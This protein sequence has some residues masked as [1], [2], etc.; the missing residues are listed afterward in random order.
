MQAVAGWSAKTVLSLHPPRGNTLPGPRTACFSQRRPGQEGEDDGHD[1]DV[2]NVVGCEGEPENYH[3]LADPALQG[4]EGQKEG[5]CVASFVA[6]A[7]TE[8]MPVGRAVLWTA[9][10]TVIQPSTTTPLPGLP[11]NQEHHKAKDDGSGS[12]G[13]QGCR[14][15][16]GQ[17]D[18][19][20]GEHSRWGEQRRWGEHS[21]RRRTGDGTWG[22]LHSRQLTSRMHDTTCTHGLT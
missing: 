6:Q 9:G 5:G 7:C 1:G 4:W 17:Q 13:Q 22:A 15:G 19:R 20:W 8:G 3:T 12:L 16:G 2:P 11:H 10:N 18:R 21:R 14:Q